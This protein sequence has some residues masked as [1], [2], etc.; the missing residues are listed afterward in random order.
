MGRAHMRRPELAN[1]QPPIWPVV[2]QHC[3]VTNIAFAHAL[4]DGQAN[5]AIAGFVISMSEIRTASMPIA[6]SEILEV[7]R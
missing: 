6:F 5:P 7:R 1:V 4:E 2:K 3:Q